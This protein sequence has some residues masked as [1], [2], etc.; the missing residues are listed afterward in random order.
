[1]THIVSFSFDDGFRKSFFKAADIFESFGHRGGFNVIAFGD[2]L[3][4]RPTV[5]GKPD[6]GMTDA[7]IGSIADWNEL[8]RRGHE[9]PAHTYD[10]TNLTTIPLEEA[11]RH[12]DLCADFF[13]E[14]LD[15]FRASDS[16]YNFAYNASTPEIEA[17][18]LT[19]FLVVRSGG[20]SPVNPIPTSRTP[21]R[22]S[23]WS[24]GPENCDAFLESTLN[25]F[26][27]SE[28]G[29]FVFNLHGLEDEGWGPISEDYLRTTLD[30]LTKLSKVEVIPVGEVVQ[31]LQKQ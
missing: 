30:R 8:V 7:L 21:V 3:D 27:A 14:H 10:H 17:Y 22:I 11:K 20:P 12:I 19:R 2:Q 6:P 28:G 1:M 16:V 26:L 25:D 29:W 5:D 13:E 24:H 4:F 18:A 31:R 9:V 15:G 23:C